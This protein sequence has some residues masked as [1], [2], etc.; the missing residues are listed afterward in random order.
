MITKEI[1]INRF[2]LLIKEKFEFCNFLFVKNYIWSIT[3]DNRSTRGIFFSM[4]VRFYIE[5]KNL[6]TIWTTRCGKYGTKKQ[7]DEKMP[8]KPRET[9][10]KRKKRQSLKDKYSR[11]FFFSWS[12]PFPTNLFDWYRRK[13][14]SVSCNRNQ[15]EI[16]LVLILSFSVDCRRFVLIEDRSSWNWSRWKLSFLSHVHLRWISLCHFIIPHSH[17]ID[18]HRSRNYFSKSRSRM[19]G[20]QYFSCLERRLCLFFS[21][22]RVLMKNKTKIDLVFF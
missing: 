11:F 22:K 20:S 13:K 3:N 10:K 2:N 17:R 9:E 15:I 21:D 4:I 7:E 19:D 14:F 18:Q 1:L 16:V 12:G 6:A 5:R 8:I